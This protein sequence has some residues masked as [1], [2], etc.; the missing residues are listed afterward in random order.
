MN[1]VADVLALDHLAVRDY[2]DEITLA[3]RSRRCARRDRSS[4]RRARRSR[5]RDQRR[6]SA[7]TR[8]R[9]WRRC[10]C[11]RRTDRRGQRRIRA[12][13][14]RRREGRRLLL[15]RRRTDHGQGARRPRRDGRARRVGRAGRSPAPRRPVQGRHPRHQPLP[16]L[17][18]RSTRPSSRCSSTSSTRPASTWRSDCCRGADV[19]LDSFTAGTMSELGLGY[20]VARELNPNIIMAT[21][22]PDRSDRTGRAARRLRLPRRRGERLLRDHRLGRPSTGRPV[23]RLHRHDRAAL[24]DDGAAG[25]ARSPPPHRRGPV[26]RPGAD[27][28]VA[29]LPRA[30]A[31][32]RAGHG[33]ER[34]AGPATIARPPPRTTP[35]RAPATTSGARSRSRPTS[36]GARCAGRSATPPGRARRALDTAQ[37]RLAQREL[38]DRQLGAFT[39]RHEPRALMDLLQAAGVPAGMVQRSSDHQQDPQLAHRRFFRPLE[40]P[41][42][43]EVPY[44]GHP[45]QIAATTMVRASRR[46][47][48]ASTPIRCSGGA[49]T[50]RR[51]GRARAGE[52]GVWMKNLPGSRLNGVGTQRARLARSLALI[53]VA[54]ALQFA[55]V[56]AAQSPSVAKAP[57]SARRSRAANPDMIGFADYHAHMFS[58]YAFGQYLFHGH[59][60]PPLDAPPDQQLADAL[61]QCRH[62]ELAPS[63]D[64]VVGA[65]HRAVSRRNE[66]HPTFADWPSYWMLLHQQMYVDWVYRAYRHGLRLMVMTITHSRTLCE[67]F[68]RSPGAPCSDDAVIAAQIDA[69]RRMLDAIAEREGGWMRLARSAREAAEII[70]ENRLALVL[71]CRGRH[72]VRLRRRGRRALHVRVVCG[73][74][75]LAVRRRR[76]ADHADPPDRQ[77]LRRRRDLRRSHEREPDVSARHARSSRIPRA[78]RTSASTSSSRAAPRA[79]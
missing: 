21:H 59:S 67:S 42:M 3:E 11:S 36:S 31:A 68:H 2:W 71:R 51:R 78:A 55:S 26:H 52:R 45:Y 60:Y 44:E 72:A 7:S 43:G 4:R 33:D 25:R 64:R 15:D 66:G 27:G 14:A 35:T 18:R 10:P 65:L 53:V 62:G 54:T 24:P 63:E 49:R 79:C 6:T 29:A 30:R 17:R 32:R 13:A 37:G 48:S 50:R 47:A 58:E 28:V 70:R 46:R 16:V 40:H 23:Q 1:T 12:A 74:A 34:R 61:G 41:E 20:D 76:P 77:R 73:G 19:C 69:T 39:A 75:R 56:S 38:I 9:C 57:P 8:R 22:V 5:R